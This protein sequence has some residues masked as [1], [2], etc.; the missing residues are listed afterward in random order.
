M[1]LGIGLSN[2]FKVLNISLQMND[3]YTATESRL[4]VLLLRSILIFYLIIFFGLICFLPSLL[5]LSL[6]LFFPYLSLPFLLSHPL[7]PSHSLPLYFF[8]SI[9]LSFPLIL[10]LFLSSLFHPILLFLLFFPYIVI[11]ANQ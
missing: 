4:S 8:L 11:N 7:L 10:Y 6:S 1:G 9:S 3:L 5:S 2:E